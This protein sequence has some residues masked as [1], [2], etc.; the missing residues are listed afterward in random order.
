MTLAEVLPSVNAA[1]NATS[2]LLLL[3]GFV[4]IKSGRRDLHQRAM[5]GAFVVSAV[6]LVSYLT[7]FALTGTTRF[8]G[9]G[10][11]KTLYLA[12]L[13]S[14]MILAIAVVPLVLRAL[15]FAFKQRFAEHRRVVKW[16]WP[17]W[18]YVSMTGVVVYLMLYHWK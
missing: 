6:F 12:I 9:E 14:H 2:F 17:I 3:G 16:L 8:Q 18:T 10:W 15:Y 7:R 13:F 11:H 4:A 1:L 5:V